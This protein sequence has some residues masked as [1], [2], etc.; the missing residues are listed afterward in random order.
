TSHVGV[1]TARGVASTAGPTCAPPPL[2]GRP[3]A[4]RASFGRRSA[5]CQSAPP[6][7]RPLPQILFLQPLTEKQPTA[8]RKPHPPGPPRTPEGSDALPPEFFALGK[9]DSVGRLF[10]VRPTDRVLDGRGL[11][12]PNGGHSRGP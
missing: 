10:R 8:P 11:N 6:E 12:P 9:T 5:V 1:P 2:W 7:S 4:G 3:A